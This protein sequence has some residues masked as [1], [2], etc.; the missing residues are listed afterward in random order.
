MNPIALF[1]GQPGCTLI[2]YHSKLDDFFQ[3]FDGCQNC[4]IAGFFIVLKKFT[5]LPACLLFI[6]CKSGDQLARIYTVR[7][8]VQ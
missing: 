3:W 2:A 1:F 6:I 4:I 8:A 7:I 5:H